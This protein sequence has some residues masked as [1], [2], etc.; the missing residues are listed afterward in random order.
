MSILVLTV[1][2][3]LFYTAFQ[4]FAKLTGGK[5][6]SNLMPIVVN[7]VAVIIQLAIY[8]YLR[9]VKH[10]ELLHTRPSGL[11]FAALA[12]LGIAGFTIFF[13]TLFQK[14]APISYISPI[15]FGASI[16]LSSLIGIILLHEKVSML[17]VV[18]SILIVAGLGLVAV[19]KLKLTS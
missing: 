11:L 18:G 9:E 16:L 2:A 1:L 8:G 12:G 6:A 15:I 13:A 19:S 7:L 5:I 14:G 10:Q 3:I 4:V 17:Q